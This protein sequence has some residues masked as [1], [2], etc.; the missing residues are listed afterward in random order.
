MFF[1]FKKYVSAYLYILCVGACTQAYIWELVLSFYYVVSGSTGLVASAL[2]CS[3][4]LSDHF[5]NFQLSL[6]EKVF[7]YRKIEYVTAIDTNFKQIK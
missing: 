3:T 5:Q 7:H 6:K 4:T 2:S 1:K